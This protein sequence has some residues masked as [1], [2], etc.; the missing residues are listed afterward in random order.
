M[1][2]RDYKA[3][4]L[5]KSKEPQNALCVD[6]GAKNP[7]WASLYY[8]TFIC[9]NCAGM[10][11]SLGV[12]LDSVR[13]IGLDAWDQQAYL[14]F[15]YGGNGKFKEYLHGRG[16][17]M[18]QTEDMYRNPAVMEYSKTLAAEIQ[19]AANVAVRYAEQRARPSSFAVAENVSK[20]RAAVAKSAAPSSSASRTSEPVPSSAPRPTAGAGGVYANGLMANLSAPN[21]SSMIPGIKDS[22]SKTA[23]AIKSKT[24]VYGSKIGSVVKDRAKSFMAA[25]SEM[26]KKQLNRSPAE[27]KSSAP[28]E[29]V[30]SR[31]QTSK[32]DWS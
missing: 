4:V 22:L 28:I 30:K 29:V 14:P 15:K 20:E 3:K 13:S 23:S 24:A 2:D 16:V 6:C 18:T 32:E 31:K 5:K 19:A 7:K 11:R 17:A 1:A 10:H 27:Q 12:L 8:G 25:G 9:L 26:M 21:I